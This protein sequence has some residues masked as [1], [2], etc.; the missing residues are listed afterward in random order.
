[1]EDPAKPAV[2]LTP[3]AAEMI[4]KF[5]AEQKIPDDQ[6]LRMGVRGGGCSGFTYDL[7]FDAPRDGDIA[8]E[9]HGVKVIVDPM[10]LRYLEG[11]E[12]DYKEDLMGGGFAIKNP[13]AKSTCGCG[14][15]FQAGEGDA[16][17]H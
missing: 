8:I 7:S 2:T 11:A 14:H 13:N 6:A 12:V 4:L 16:P 3:K 5:R 15:S 10:S 17:Q 1:M 9:M